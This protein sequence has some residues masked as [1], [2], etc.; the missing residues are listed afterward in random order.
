VNVYVELMCD[1]VDVEGEYHSYYPQTQ[2]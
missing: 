2:T 1:T